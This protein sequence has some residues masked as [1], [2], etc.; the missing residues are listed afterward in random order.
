MKDRLCTPPVLAYPNF[1]LPFI[2]TTDS[3]QLAVAVVLSQ[4]QGGM[5]Q[6]LA[7]AS[8]QL[9]QAERVYSA[10][11]VTIILCQCH[12]HKLGCFSAILW[13]TKRLQTVTG[14]SPFILPPTWE[15]DA[16]A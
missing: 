15:R 3:S 7:Y 1:E 12:Q 4:V 11:E 16:A 6:P 13:P 2:L 8:R 10:T 14:Y 9:N 5:E